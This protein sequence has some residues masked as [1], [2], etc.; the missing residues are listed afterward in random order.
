ML[1]GC[2]SG[3]KVGPTTVVDN[4]EPVVEKIDPRLVKD[5]EPRYLYP[6]GSMSIAAITDR[7]A[8]VE[9]ALAICRNQLELIRA[10]QAGR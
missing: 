9:D 5:C 7:A 8:A 10:A 1:A 3:P 6:A 4:P 2:A